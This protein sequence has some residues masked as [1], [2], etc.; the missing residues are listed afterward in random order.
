MKITTN[1]TIFRAFAL[2]VALAL[3][4]L[5]AFSAAYD[6]M[7]AA[8]KLKDYGTVDE[9]LAKGMDPDSVDAQGNTLLMQAA[10]EGDAQMVATI[11]KWKPRLEAVNANG[12]TALA[13][14]AWQGTLP[15]AEK[16]LAAG[17]SFEAGWPPLVYAA[18]N[19]HAEVV[20]FLLEHGAPVNLPS[21]SGLTAL[22][23]AARG[24][25]E[26]VVRLLVDKGAQINLVSQNDETALDLAEKNRNT[27]IADFLRG[28]G[29]LEG[30]TLKN[31]AIGT[32]ADSGS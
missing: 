31:R 22:M 20:R 9:L 13:I 6:D 25:H 4:P 29:G 1:S 19:G 12:E 14:A 17:A 18:F 5:P 27:D 2:C 26:D 24:G 3:S 16:L 8:V 30:K 11:L 21:D 32:A 28:R 23:A 15:V 10:R 7:M